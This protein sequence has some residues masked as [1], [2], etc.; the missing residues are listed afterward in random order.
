MKCLQPILFIYN[1][2]SCRQLLDVRERELKADLLPKHVAQLLW[3]YVS[4]LRNNPTAKVS[5]YH[6]GN[7]LEGMINDVNHPSFMKCNLVELN[8]VESALTYL[9]DKKIYFEDFN[10]SL[11]DDL[12]RKSAGKPSLIHAYIR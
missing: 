10:T 3:S 11:E 2:P 5:S 6:F 1:V 9:V 12:K 7:I 8:Q 4:I